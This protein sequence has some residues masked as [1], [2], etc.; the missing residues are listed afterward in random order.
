[1]SVSGAQAA[2]FFREVV[3][4]GT[5]WWVRDDKG[6]PTPRGV[7]PYWSSQGRA[8]RAAALWGPEF[9]V[10]AMPVEQWRD[11]ALPDL[12]ADDFRVGINWS[13]Q[14]LTGWDFTVGEVLNRLGAG[15]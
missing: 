11:A 2:A 8:Q 4:H 9:R 3:Q 1:V 7:F 5:V 6:S 15:A 10:V 12:A 14:R 13:G